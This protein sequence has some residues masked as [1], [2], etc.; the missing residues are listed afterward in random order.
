M[1]VDFLLAVLR[2]NRKSR[3]GFVVQF[4]STTTF[5]PRKPA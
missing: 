3:S 2:N 1:V 4:L 5:S